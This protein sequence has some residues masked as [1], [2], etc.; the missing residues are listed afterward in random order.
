MKSRQIAYRWT[1]IYPSAPFD[2]IWLFS[3]DSNDEDLKQ[4]ILGLL[5]CVV[6]NLPDQAT[7]NWTVE[8]SSDGL[9]SGHEPFQ[10][11]SLIC[12][13]QSRLSHLEPMKQCQQ[14][15]ARVNTQC[16][17]SSLQG[18]RHKKQCQH[19]FLKGMMRSPSICKVGRKQ[20]FLLMLCCPNL[21]FRRQLLH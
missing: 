3:A 14:S 19:I 15:V 1:V 6:P 13:Q 5:S 4:Q 11:K 8:R 16:H 18:M 9:E 12:R 17:K 2:W 10:P 21:L 20:C 7:S